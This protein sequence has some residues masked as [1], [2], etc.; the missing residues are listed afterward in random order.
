MRPRILGLGNELLGDDAVGVLAARQIGAELVDQVEVV[1]TSVYGLALLD[2][3]LGCR[4]LVIIDA[5]KTGQVPPGTVIQL[6]PASLD[7]VVAPSPHYSGLPEMRALA[8]RLNLDFPDQIA[9]FAV[10]IADGSRLEVRL[11]EEVKAGLITVVQRVRSHLAE[12]TVSPTL[13]PDQVPDG[14]V[15]QLPPRWRETVR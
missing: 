4:Q 3:I 12:W 6:D 1:E 13:L 9:I 7:H 14:R 5:I 10:E 8:Q 15:E 11:S 2:V